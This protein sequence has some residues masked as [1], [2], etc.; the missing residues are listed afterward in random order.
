MQCEQCCDS[1]STSCTWR[2]CAFSSWRRIYKCQ[3]RTK[4]PPPQRRACALKLG[5]CH[6]SPHAACIAAAAAGAQN[7]NNEARK[8]LAYPEQVRV[9]LLIDNH[10]LTPPGDQSSAN[11]SIASQSKQPRREAH[12]ATKSKPAKTLHPCVR[13]AE[14]LPAARL[15]GGGGE[16]GAQAGSSRSCH[17]RCFTHAAAGCP[18]VC[19]F[20][21][22]SLLLLCPPLQ[23]HLRQDSA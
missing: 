10:D 1:R 11:Q 23:A 2:G 21:C 22:V 3:Q 9:H 18:V 20:A 12:S 6:V 7:E 4:L 5:A 15:M 8:Q 17:C 16:R 13:P 19:A 14:I